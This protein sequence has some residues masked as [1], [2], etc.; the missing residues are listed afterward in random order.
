MRAC[1]TPASTGTSR[2]ATRRFFAEAELGGAIHNGALSGATPPM[3]DLGCRELFFW[4]VGVGYR[5]N[6]HWNLMATEQHG[7]QWGLCG[8]DNNQGINYLGVRLGYRY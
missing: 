7:S 2:W 5:L 4:S 3:R 1:C 6:E 8:W